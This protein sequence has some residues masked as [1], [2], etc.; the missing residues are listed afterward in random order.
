MIIYLENLCYHR[1]F[2]CDGVC[3]L[4]EQMCVRGTMVKV[5]DKGKQSSDSQYLMLVVYH[6]DLI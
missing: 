2:R 1:G 6:S 3:L 4:L 5:S